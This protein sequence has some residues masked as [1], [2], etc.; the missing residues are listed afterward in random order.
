MISGVRMDNKVQIIF[1]LQ[2]KWVLGRMIS[3]PLQH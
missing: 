3:P 1:A 2:L